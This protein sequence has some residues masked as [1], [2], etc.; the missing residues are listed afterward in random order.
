MNVSIHI[1]QV[2]KLDVEIL[3]FLPKIKGF[4]TGL[5]FDPAASTLTYQTK[6][7]PLFCRY[8]PV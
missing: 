4:G 5:V 2:L 1:S 3:P 6:V 7:P 8:K